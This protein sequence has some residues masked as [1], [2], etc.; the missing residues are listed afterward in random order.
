MLIIIIILIILYY[1]KK[2]D[3]F[4]NIPYRL[5]D[6]ILYPQYLLD[7]SLLPMLGKYPDSIGVQY[8]FKKFP[9]ITSS[10]NITENCKD[11]IKTQIKD[12]Y[13]Y[14]KILFNLIKNNKDYNSYNHIFLDNE[15]V[16]HIR[17]GDVLCKYNTIFPNSNKTYAQIY[18]KYGDD[19]WWTLVNEYIVNNNI[20]TIYL[21]YGSHTNK[22]IKESTE[23]VKYVKIEH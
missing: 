11:I 14:T 19:K 10:K 9:C 18:S 4:D 2:F 7:E 16:I 8:I 5:A 13:I 6:L 12:N 21:I 23:Y 20:N 1:D 3:F 15:I 22:C 17:I